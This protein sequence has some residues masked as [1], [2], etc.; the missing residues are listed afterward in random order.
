M[1]ADSCSSS[2]IA[3]HLQA[4]ALVLSLHCAFRF[5]LH[6]Y[7]CPMLAVSFSI[8]VIAQCFQIV[9]TVLPL[10]NAL[11]FLLKFYLCPLNAYFCSSFVIPYC[12]QTI[13]PYL[14]MH[15]FFDKLFVTVQFTTWS[16]ALT[17]RII[18]IQFSAQ[19]SCFVMYLCIVLYHYQYAHYLKLAF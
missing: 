11:K 19:T 13:V 2:L 4:F 15:V 5:L 18:C 3:Q 9:A 7:H 16:S 6:L 10:P 17:K 12:L 8:S 14:S 1:L